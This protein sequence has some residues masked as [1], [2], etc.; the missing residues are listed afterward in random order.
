MNLTYFQKTLIS[1][2]LICFVFFLGGTVIRSAIAFDLFLPNA[3]FELKHEFTNEMR[4]Q[5]M[6]VYAITAFYT[7]FGYGITFLI[8]T[9]LLFSLK[10][11][12]K[13]EGWLFM[14]FTLF[15]LTAPIN[16]FTIYY[17]YKLNEA[18]MYNHLTDFN[19]WDVQHWFVERYKDLRINSAS[20]ISFFASITCL[21]F[22]IWQPLK[23]Q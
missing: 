5:S 10:K 22:L 21:V 20:T 17:D 7:D 3:N 13:Q 12:F 9:S 11:Y 18:I 4:M 6:Y 1:I 15:F 19:S 16:A 8:M 14:I 2:A 23:K